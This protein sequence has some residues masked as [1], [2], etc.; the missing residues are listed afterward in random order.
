MNVN[1]I[2]PRNGLKAQGSVLD[3]PKIS[4]YMI[5]GSGP[6][7]SDFDYIVSDREYDISYFGS[8]P[9]NP[10]QAATAVPFSANNF[11]NPISQIAELGIVSAPSL[12]DLD[13]QRFDVSC[14]LPLPATYPAFPLVDNYY[15]TLAAAPIPS[16]YMV[17]GQLLESV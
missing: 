14:W 15:E 6:V 3:S 4:P 17:S 12:N 7:V 11:L 9:S 5:S 13:P 1:A 2:W 8:A 10:A 16:Y